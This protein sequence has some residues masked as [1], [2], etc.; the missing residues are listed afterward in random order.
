MLRVTC[1][2]I[3][4]EGKV[5]VTQ[6]SEKMKQPLKWEFPGG[7]VEK[8]ESEE[9]CLQREIQEELNIKIK[10]VKK[11]SPNVHVYTEITIQLIPFVCQYQAGEIHLLEHARYE[12][13]DKKEL[14]NLDWAEADIPILKEYL[15]GFAS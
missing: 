2:I 10:P 7:K 11:L 5:L 13:L 8:G 1:A 4:K 15:A 3:E 12:W 14:V 6:R 9:E